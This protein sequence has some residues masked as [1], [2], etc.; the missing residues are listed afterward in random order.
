MRPISCSGGNS[1]TWRPPWPALKLYVAAAVLP[2]GRNEYRRF[3]RLGLLFRQRHVAADRQAERRVGDRQRRAGAVGRGQFQFA[4]KIEVV[5]LG[6][7]QRHA[8][9]MAGLGVPS[10]HRPAERRPREEV[11]VDI[12]VGLVAF[13]LLFLPLQLLLFESLRPSS[14]ACGDIRRSRAETPRA[15]AATRAKPAVSCVS[16]FR[17]ETTPSIP[18]LRPVAHGPLG[19]SPRHSRPCKGERSGGLGKPSVTS[20]VCGQSCRQNCTLCRSCR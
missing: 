17:A 16:P 19:L 11:A 1:T 3:E 6:V 7:F 13:F 20:L 18:S 14:G 9:P 15:S 10:E 5:G 8:G 4:D 12:E 2:P